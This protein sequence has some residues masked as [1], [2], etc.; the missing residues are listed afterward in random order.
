MLHEGNFHQFEIYRFYPLQSGK[1]EMQLDSSNLTSEISRS[2]LAESLQSLFS[3]SLCSL[4]NQHPSNNAT[5]QEMNSASF[6]FFFLFIKPEKRM[7]KNHRWVNLRLVAATKIRGST[8]GRL[9]RSHT[10]SHVNMNKAALWLYSPFSRFC[11]GKNLVQEK[12][13]LW[14]TT[15][16]WLEPRV[17]TNR[18]PCL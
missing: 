4:T 9:I 17:W 16:R 11:F 1:V 7:K 10:F 13:A 15:G 3:S 14:L 12:S 6:S 8:H 5:R 18:R 2:H